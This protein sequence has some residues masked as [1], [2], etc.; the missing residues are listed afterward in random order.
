MSA[1]GG[2]RDHLARE[3]RAHKVRLG[4]VL[5]GFASWQNRAGPW[6]R[7]SRTTRWKVLGSWG[8]LRS[9]GVVGF[10]SSQAA[11]MESRCMSKATFAI[12]GSMAVSPGVRLWPLLGWVV[13]PRNHAGGRP[14]RTNYHLIIVCSALPLR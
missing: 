4:R 14:F 7:S 10:E 12:C 8:V 1:G 11:V 9:S 13:N 3:P 6:L 2:R 5:A